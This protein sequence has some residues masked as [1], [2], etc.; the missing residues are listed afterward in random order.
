[1]A[2]DDAKLVELAHLARLELD[3]ARNAQ[4]KDDLGRMLAM[5]EQL[6]SDD[7]EPGA[8]AKAKENSSAP[9]LRLRPDQAKPAPDQLASLAPRHERGFVVVPQTID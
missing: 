2:I 5:V 7:H 4:L 9:S 6:G 3:P 8:K 1:M